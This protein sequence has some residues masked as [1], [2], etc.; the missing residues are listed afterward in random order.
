M[1]QCTEGTALIATLAEPQRAN[2][3]S[4]AQWSGLVASARQANLLGALAVRIQDAGVEV[5]PQVL[6]HLKGAQQLSE[7]QHRSVLWEVHQLQQALCE[8]DIP[9][10]LLKGAAYVMSNDGVGVGRLFGDID[11]LVP[12]SALGDVESQLML[13]GWVS[14]KTSAYDQRYYRQWMHEIPPMSHIRRGTV[15]DVHHTILPLTSRH[16]PDPQQI[17]ARALPVSEPGLPMIRVPCQ[18]DLVI[19]SIVHLMHEGELHNGLRDLNDI[20]SMLRK[21]GPMPGFW[22]RLAG[23]AVGN[24]L[25]GPVGLGLAL[26]QKVFGTP[27]PAFVHDALTQAQGG[28]R[29][30][31]WLLATFDLALDQQR[32]NGTDPTV[33]IAQ[34]LIYVRSH[35]LRM[36]LHLVVPHLMRKAWMGWFPEKK[37]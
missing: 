31:S 17:I 35:R 12:R 25:A 1:N 20:D 7:R 28:R 22:A 34:W 10:V 36:P 8:L 18:V 14:A 4:A 11:I 27:I 32:R 3:L 2:A 21:F 33:A 29:P 26:V 5:P 30:A 15:I 13:H 9:V 19:H 23:I 24:D 37:S 16:K 6:R